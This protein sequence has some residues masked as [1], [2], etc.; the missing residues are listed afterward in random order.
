MSLILNFLTEISVILGNHQTLPQIRIDDVE[1]ASYLNVTSIIFPNNLRL[2]I[3]CRLRT[4][5][6]SSQIRDQGSHV[7]KYKQ[8]GGATRGL[9][10]IT[11]WTNYFSVRGPFKAGASNIGRHQHRRVQSSC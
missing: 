1:A 9:L 10:F 6:R 2:I 4:C 11:L 8:S 7:E 3:I 5:V